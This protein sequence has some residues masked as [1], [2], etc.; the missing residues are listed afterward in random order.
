M[1]VRRPAVP[2]ERM[3]DLPALFR[4]EFPRSKGEM[5]MAR[6]PGRVN[7]IGEHTDYNE[8][9]VLPVA[10]SLGVRVQVERSPELVVEGPS[11]NKRSAEYV[12][13]VCRALGLP[14]E[15]LGRHSASGKPLLGP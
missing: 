14:A 1:S 3:P 7:L 11:A 9:F 10:L 15:R 8:G 12:A 4:E 13:A 6:A 5:V 2:A